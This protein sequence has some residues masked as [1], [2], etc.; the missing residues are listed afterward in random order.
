MSVSRG[1]SLGARRP[2]WS[3]RRVGVTVVVSASLGMQRSGWLMLAARKAAPRSA[4]SPHDSDGSVTTKHAPPRV[5][6]PSSS[7]PRISETK[8]ETE[9]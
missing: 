4:D 6:V 8:R 3:L 7:A 9:R 2:V 5:E 1:V